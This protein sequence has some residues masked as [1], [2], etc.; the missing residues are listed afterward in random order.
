MLRLS[1]TEISVSLYGMLE[2]KIKSDLCGDTT[3]R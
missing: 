1:S 3:I 2:D